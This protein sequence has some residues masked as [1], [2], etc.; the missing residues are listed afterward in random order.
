MMPRRRQTNKLS[1]LQIPPRKARYET[2]VLKAHTFS[3]HWVISHGGCRQFAHCPVQ[4]RRV[5]E[6]FTFR[7]RCLLA[8]LVTCC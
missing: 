8:E 3:V 1:L 7:P 2:L 4:V 5:P 6:L